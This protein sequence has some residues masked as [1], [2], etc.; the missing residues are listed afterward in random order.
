MKD[1]KKNRV[2]AKSPNLYLNSFKDSFPSMTGRKDAKGA[3]RRASSSLM[4]VRFGG[5]GSTFLGLLHNGDGDDVGVL[6][7]GKAIAEEALS[8]LDNQKTFTK[9]VQILVS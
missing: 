1:I 5:R 2:K 4:S 8:T 9:S 6:S 7:T 3:E